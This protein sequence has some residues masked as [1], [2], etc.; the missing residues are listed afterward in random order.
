MAPRRTAAGART[1]WLQTTAVRATP[2][3]PPNPPLRTR[4]SP[5]AWRPRGCVWRLPSRDAARA[6][7]GAHGGGGAEGGSVGR[8]GALAGFA[9]SGVVRGGAASEDKGAG[10]A[11]RRRRAEFD[12]D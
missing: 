7:S 3:A 2:R 1:K 12:G 9:G 8:G 4:R 10:G 6:G 5:D 11:P